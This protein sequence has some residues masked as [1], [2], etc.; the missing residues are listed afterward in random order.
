MFKIDAHLV[1]MSD[2]RTLKDSSG[3]DVGQ[4]RKKKT[5]GLH[6]TYYV[7]TMNDDK[8]CAVKVKG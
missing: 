5:P 6:P 8:K 7:G 1:S 4:V 3:N 2:R